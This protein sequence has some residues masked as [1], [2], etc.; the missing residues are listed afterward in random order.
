MHVIWL[1]PLKIRHKSGHNILKNNNQTAIKCDNYSFWPTNTVFSPLN[2]LGC[3]R[4]GYFCLGR[5]PLDIPSIP[6]VPRSLMDSSV[7]ESSFFSTS[8]SMWQNDPHH[9][10]HQLCCPL[11]G[12]DLGWRPQHCPRHPHLQDVRQ[13]APGLLPGVHGQRHGQSGRESNLQLPGRSINMMERLRQ[14]DAY[15]FRLI[16]TRQAT[17]RSVI[18]RLIAHASIPP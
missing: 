8:E 16:E 2:R 13:L 5:V 9:G 18:E 15:E 3:V 4:F 11:D 6:F 17:K 14:I 12:G 1:F 7:A 10:Q